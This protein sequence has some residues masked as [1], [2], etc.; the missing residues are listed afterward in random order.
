M[1]DFVISDW[2]F[3]HRRIL[4]FERTEF[5]DCKEH[6]DALVKGVNQ[7]LRKEDTLYFLGDIGFD[8]SRIKDMVACRKIMIK[9]NHDCCSKSKLLAAGFDEVVDHPIF[10]NKF[11]ILSHEPIPVSEHFI[12]IHGHLH[13]AYL[14]SDRHI[15]VSAKLVNYKPVSM[16]AL[17]KKRIMD[18]PRIEAP[19]MH[20]WYADRYVFLTPREEIVYD[21]AGNIDV[22]KSRHNVDLKK[23][24]LKKLKEKSL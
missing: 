1:A 6:D 5:A 24:K 12:N 21:E 23:E 3:S 19:F 22:E 9:G 13:G 16:N 11:V 7:T 4:E 8:L 2:H 15:N 17:L 18:L 10:Y 20:E 14:N